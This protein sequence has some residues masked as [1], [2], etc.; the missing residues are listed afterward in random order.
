MIK[1][2]VAFT[3]IGQTQL[4]AQQLEA[5]VGFMASTALVRD[6]G[7]SNA[8]ARALGN[9]ATDVTE[10]KLR[11]APVASVLVASGI[12]G[13]AALEGSMSLGFSQLIA[14]NAESSWDA[15]NVTIGSLSVGVRY[16]YWRNIWLNGGVGVTRFF[17][18]S[19]GIFSEGSSLNPLLEAGVMTRLP[20]N[21][22]MH[23][24]ARIQTHG[25]GTA[26][27]RREGAGDGKTLRFMLQ[28]GFGR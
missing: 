14:S 21:L 7:A 15:Q 12:G 1:Y 13:R 22:P 11:A 20:I 3:L 9:I 28:L 25:F 17:S 4:A 8:L 5:R 6:D 2:L 26:A 19:R 27:L 18:D 23:V 24:A 16:E 10:L